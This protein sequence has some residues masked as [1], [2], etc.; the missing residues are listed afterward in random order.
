MI[1][2]ISK[3]IT[4]DG[5]EFDKLKE[6][7]A[8]EKFNAGV[9][10]ETKEL[11]L[12]QLVFKNLHSYLIDGLCEHYSDQVFNFLVKNRKELLQLL[13]CGNLDTVYRATRTFEKPI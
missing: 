6:A 10:A 12:R 7:E 2:E 13:T 11:K 1:R 4:E 9:I 8:H 5:R 3:Y